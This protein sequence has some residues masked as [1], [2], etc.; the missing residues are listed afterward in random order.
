MSQ[1]ESHVYVRTCNPNCVCVQTTCTSNRSLCSF[2]VRSLTSFNLNPKEFAA[3]QRFQLT[4]KAL[5]FVSKPQVHSNCCAQ[6]KGF[7]CLIVR[8]FTIRRNRRIAHSLLFNLSSFIV[9]FNSQYNPI[10]ISSMFCVYCCVQC[11]R[12]CVFSSTPNLC[13]LFSHV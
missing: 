2:A 9:Q 13:Y 1:P 3:N 12:V 4:G 11:S 5:R 10:L 6:P 7:A 8:F